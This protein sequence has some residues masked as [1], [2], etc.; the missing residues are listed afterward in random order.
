MPFLLQTC[1]PNPGTAYPVFQECLL[2]RNSDCDVVVPHDSVS[3]HHARIVSLGE[4]YVVEDLNSRNGTKLNNLVIQG[5]CQLSDGDML[6]LSAVEFEFREKPAPRI[7]S[8]QILDCDTDFAHLEPSSPTVQLSLDMQ[9]RF[10]VAR[11]GLTAQAKLHA[12]LDITQNLGRC[13][14]QPKI[15]DQSMDCLLAMIPNAEY[16]CIGM[17]DEYGHLSRV[18]S[19]SPHKSQAQNRISRSIAEQAMNSKRAILSQDAL[20]DP[21]FRHQESVSQLQIRSIMCAPLVDDNGEAFGAI[22]VETG[23]W[24][25]PFHQEDL[26][27]L[28]GIA[29]QTA[30]AI[31]VARLHERE[32]RRRTMERDLEL[33]ASVQRDLLPKQAPAVEGYEFADHYRPAEIVGG[34]YFDYVSTPSNHL[35]VIVADVAGHGIAAAISM[36]KLSAEVRLLTSSMQSPGEVLTELNDNLWRQHLDSRFITLLIAVLDPQTHLVTLSCAGQMPPLVRLRSGKLVEP[37]RENYGPP[38]GAL[39]RVRFVEHQF[40]MQPEDV[41]VLYT[42]GITEAANSEGEFYGIERLRSQ[43]AGASSARSIRDGVI[44]DL[45]Q[46]MGEQPPEDD[47]CLV[48]L[49]RQLV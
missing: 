49:G 26:E 16:T 34:D 1:G 41:L 22:Q 32:L 7:T 14:S 5:R 12:L 44:S 3:R 25:R 30:M 4:Y 10:D 37:D 19:K 46:F 13:F 21:R 40:S 17:R 27:L 24:L 18:V 15:F 6:R 48:A 36:S 2:G 31:T 47:M 45:A 11:I 29:A 39:E 43:I 38:L 28:M 23:N 9:P 35:A 8:G 33:A 42:D 20:H